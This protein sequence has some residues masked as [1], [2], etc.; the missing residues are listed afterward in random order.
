[1]TAVTKC[2]PGLSLSSKGGEKASASGDR[3]PSHTEQGVQET[4]LLLPPGTIFI[5]IGG[6]NHSQFGW[7]GNQPGDA[8]ATISR[9]EQQAQVLQA[10][11]QLLA[12][13]Q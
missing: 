2:Y 4:K 5:I 9:E 11:L 12:G 1:M 8:E 6:G 3:V 7:Y 10:T 13:L